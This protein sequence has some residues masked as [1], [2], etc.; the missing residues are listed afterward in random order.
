MGNVLAFDNDCWATPPGLAFLAKKPSYQGKGRAEA[1]GKRNR[2]LPRP[3]SA[4]GQKLTS[5]PTNDMSASAKSGY[6]PLQAR[7]T[8][9]VAAELTEA[10]ARGV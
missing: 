1:S 6:L 2:C 10:T 3:M 4:S 5:G 8:S 7:K 9:F